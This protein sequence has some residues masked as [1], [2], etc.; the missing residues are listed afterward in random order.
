MK[1]AKSKTEA[2][3][4]C[5]TTAEIAPQNPAQGILNDH[6]EVFSCGGVYLGL[7][8]QSP[9]LADRFDFV[10][11]PNHAKDVV[12]LNNQ[13]IHRRPGTSDAP[14]VLSPREVSSPEE[15]LRRFF[16]ESLN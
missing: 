7:N 16:K 14:G 15:A 9:K 8:R 5:G 12:V 4:R 1:G 3:R 11:L 13:R 10:H 6:R 2:K